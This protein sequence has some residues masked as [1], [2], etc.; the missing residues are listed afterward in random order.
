MSA[1]HPEADGLEGKLSQYS[2]VIDSYKGV[3][4]GNYITL[5]VL[6]WIELAE[7][8]DATSYWEYYMAPIL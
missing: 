4:K 2:A 3:G 8:S 7:R 5:A 1:T 6:V